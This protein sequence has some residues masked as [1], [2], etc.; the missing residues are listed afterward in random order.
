[1][2]VSRCF[3]EDDQRALD[4][5]DS[6]TKGSRSAEGSALNGGRRIACAE[7]LPRRRARSPAAGEGKARR[8]GRAVGALRALPAAVLQSPSRPR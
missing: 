3:Q 5:R 1:M 8:L 7:P 6:A 4:W 2:S